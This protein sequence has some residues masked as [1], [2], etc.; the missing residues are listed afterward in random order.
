MDIRLQNKKKQK[1]SV[2]DKLTDALIKKLTTTVW[3]LEE[4]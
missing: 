3:Q 1:N 2:K 4:M